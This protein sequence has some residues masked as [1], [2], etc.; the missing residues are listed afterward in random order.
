MS[1]CLFRANFGINGE[2]RFKFQAFINPFDRFSKELILPSN[3]VIRTSSVISVNIA[4][5]VSAPFAS[6]QSSDQTE[7]SKI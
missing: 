4:I 3:S 1:E 6:Y 5:F 7:N 2:L